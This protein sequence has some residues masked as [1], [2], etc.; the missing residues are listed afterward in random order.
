[1]FVNVAFDTLSVCAMPIVTI[2]HRHFY[3]YSARMYDFYCHSA[4]VPAFFISCTYNNPTIVSAHYFSVQLLE[5]FHTRAFSIF[6]FSSY[7][8]TQ[9]ASSKTSTTAVATGAPNASL[10][11]PASVPALSQVTP[12]PATTKKPT[13]WPTVKS[14]VCPA[15][16][17]HK[18]LWKLVLSHLVHSSHHHRHNHRGL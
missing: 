11:N 13:V 1:M 6:T 4:D 16:G 12:S 8:K 5:Y 7:T 9:C 17:H 14:Y 3:S 10:A 2:Q 18:H 15:R